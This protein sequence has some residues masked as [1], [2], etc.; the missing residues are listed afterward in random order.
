ML[1]AGT[2]NGTSIRQYVNFSTGMSETEAAAGDDWDWVAHIVHPRVVRDLGIKVRCPVL[3][4]DARRPK[5]D[6]S[7]SRACRQ[8][9]LHE[10]RIE[11]RKSSAKRVTDLQV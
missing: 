9:K 7:D 1:L 2:N 4:S 6:T 10:H 8:I 3:I 5:R 11:F